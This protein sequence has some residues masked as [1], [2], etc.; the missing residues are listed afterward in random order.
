MTE[1]IKI[2]EEYLS[3]EGFRPKIDDYGDFCF[4][5]EGKTFYIEE[6]DKDELFLRIVYPC[7]WTIES[8]EERIA[9]QE[10]INTVNSNMKVAK[11][12]IVKF[13]NGQ[14]DV[15]ATV[16]IF[17]SEL[18]EN[19]SKVFPRCISALDGAYKKFIKLMQND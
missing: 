2:I 15:F 1:F 11:L 19:L 14:E 16:E 18:K 7:F 12:Y 3:S 4:K 6:E 9:V 5:F 13:K 10:A 8:P 17:I